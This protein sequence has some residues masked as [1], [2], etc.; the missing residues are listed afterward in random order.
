MVASLRNRWEES[1]Q[2]L[3]IELMQEQTLDLN[4]AVSHGISLISEAWYK[5]VQSLYDEPHRAY[6]NWTHVEDVLLSIDFLMHNQ[7]QMDVTLQDVAITTLA[8]FFHDAIYNP[9]SSTNEK[10]S[11]DLFDKFVSELHAAVVS[12]LKSQIEGQS[13][14]PTIQEG[15]MKSMI[16]SKVIEC[17]ISSATHIQSSMEANQSNNIVVAIFLDADISILGKSPDVYD[18]YAGCI[19][20]EYI[21]VER[22][23]YCVKRAEILEGFL[24]QGDISE[25]AVDE[26]TKKHQFVFATDRG[27]AEWERSAQINLKREIDL[28]RCGIIPCENT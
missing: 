19:R 9:K 21:F 22:D 1:V 25:L 20:K 26:K 24:P 8:A 11:A 2:Q 23:M 12:T 14:N 16:A 3:V 5:K 27:R 4:Q 13:P 18:R 10:D 15:K 28:L 6:H 7:E 17:I